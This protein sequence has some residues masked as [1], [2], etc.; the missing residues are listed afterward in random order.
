M[1]Q[2]NIYLHKNLFKEKVFISF[3]TNSKVILE[4]KVQILCQ[5]NT[6]GTIGSD[7]ALNCFS[8]GLNREKHALQCCRELSSFCPSSKW[9]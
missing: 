7:V 4:T 9:R 6:S 8:L 1:A 2:I 5:Q 3:C